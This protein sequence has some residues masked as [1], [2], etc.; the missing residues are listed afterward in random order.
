MPLHDRSSQLLPFAPRPFPDEL[1]LSWICRLAAANHTRV[2]VLFPELAAMNRYRLNCNPNESIIHR[3][4]AMARVPHSAVL[5]LLLPSQFPNLALLTFLHPP[6]PSTLFSNEYRWELPLPLCRD[7]ACEKERS[8]RGL[9]WTAET[10]LPIS[11]LCHKHGTCSEFA[12]PGCDGDR[13]ILA[14]N[15][16]GLIVRCLR[17]SWL[18]VS[19]VKEE[20]F[21]VCPSAS[22][23]L[24]F[25]FQRDIAIALRGQPP[26][27]FWLGSIPA[28]QF[29]G[30]VD[31]LCWLLR[32]PGLSALH[33][34]EFTFTDGFSWI[35]LCTDSRTLFNRTRHLP[36]SAW[37]RGTRAELLIAAA[38]TMLGSR[39][40]GVLQRKP[41]C[42]VP[43]AFYPWDWIFP[44]LHKR[45]AR[46]LLK[47]AATWP[48]TLQLPL[49]AVADKRSYLSSAV[50]AYSTD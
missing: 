21:S 24:F 44:S 20:T 18:P 31:D 30:I 40:F 35:K 9:Y 49:L 23:Q 15:Q 33:R 16:A 6:G 2:D 41:Y 26:S 11:A 34:E 8:S 4:A 14:W 37:D 1:L 12:C 38:V 50:P 7:C 13:L 5:G 45:H 29:L 22:L 17:C 46:H 32:T 47:R 43:S 27:N 39:A 3:L 28:I 42:T 10:G 19:R 48:L 36:F 25:R